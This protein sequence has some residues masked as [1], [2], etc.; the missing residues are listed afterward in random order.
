MQTD[1]GHNHESVDTPSLSQNAV[2]HLPSTLSALI[3]QWVVQRL[4]E[5]FLLTYESTIDKP[6]QQESLSSRRAHCPIS[7][8]ADDYGNM[9][10]DVTCT[11][12]SL[13][14]KSGYGANE[15]TGV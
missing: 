14:L 4:V 9:V 8:R 15:K 11:P 6:D 3:S 10:E 1:T 7:W 2:S 12:S 5:D 13:W